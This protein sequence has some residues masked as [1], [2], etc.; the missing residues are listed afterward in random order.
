MTTR[1]KV[2]RSWQIEVWWF[3][4][5]LPQKGEQCLV[6]LFLFEDNWFVQRIC[7]GTSCIVTCWPSTRVAGMCRPSR[8]KTEKNVVQGLGRHSGNM[9]VCC[10]SLLVCLV[11]C[12]GRQIPRNIREHT[13]N[14]WLNCNKHMVDF[15]IYK[16]VA[17]INKGILAI[18]STG[19]EKGFI[20]P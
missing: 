4:A 6:H 2:D 7:T 5:G 13:K 11:K 12:P 9:H 8:P 10:A 17:T 15:V 3:L 20:W 14:T 1:F 18:R 16:L 19:G